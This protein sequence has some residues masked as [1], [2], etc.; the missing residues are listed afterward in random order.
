MIKNENHEEADLE[1]MLLIT[2]T[3]TKV[4]CR[5]KTRVM[6]AHKTKFLEES[7]VLVMKIW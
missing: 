3:G 6:N 5:I 7:M 4:I 1:I 2:N